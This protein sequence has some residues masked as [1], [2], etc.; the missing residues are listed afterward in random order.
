MGTSIGLLGID[1]LGTLHH[2]IVR[3]IKR[4]RIFYDDLDRVNFIKR[5]GIVSTESDTAGFAWALIPN[6]GLG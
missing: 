3:G 5:F 1:M 6:H 2:I 4:R